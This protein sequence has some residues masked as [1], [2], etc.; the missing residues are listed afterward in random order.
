MYWRMLATDPKKTA[1]FVLCG[2]PTI[3]Q[4]E[5]ASDPVFLEKMILTLG[6]VSSIVSKSP[7]EIFKHESI[8]SRL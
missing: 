4:Q 2:K 1:E 5:L 7:E 8:I 6:C 3:Q